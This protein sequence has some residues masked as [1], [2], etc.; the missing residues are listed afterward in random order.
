MPIDKTKL[1]SATTIKYKKGSKPTYPHTIDV[2]ID[3][4]FYSVPQ[5]EGNTDFIN[6]Q[7]W[8]AEGNTIAEAD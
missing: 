8:V 7:E 5:D 2:I 6:I 4:K 3:G 1:N